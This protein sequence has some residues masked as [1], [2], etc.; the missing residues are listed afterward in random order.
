MITRNVRL[1]FKTLRGSKWRSLMT[2]TGIILGIV[3]VVTV[4]SLGEGIKRQ[5]LSQISQQG[6]NLITVRPGNFVKRDNSG[7]IVGV[8]GWN[9]LTYTSGSLSETDLDVVGRTPGVSYAVPMTLVNSGVKLDEEQYVGGSVIASTEQLPAALNQKVIYGKFF[10]TNELDRHVAVIGKRVAEQLFKE[11]VPI[12]R[13]LTIRGQDFVV[14][15]IF[16]E[17]ADSPLP[18]NPD[19][20]KAVFIPHGLSIG[21][22]SGRQLIQILVRPQSG[23]SNQTL[24]ANLN[25]QLQVA[26]GG[27]VDYT[28][29]AQEENLAL[30]G[31]V[32]DMFTSFIGGI[33]AIMLLIGGLGI[34]NIMLV[35][36]SERTRE[37]GI[38]KA[39]GATNRQIA[40]QFFVEATV[41]SC[42]GGAIGIILAY[43]INLTLRILTHLQPVTTWPVVLTASGVSLAI[44]ILFGLIP[45]VRAARKDPIEALR[46]E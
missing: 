23:I 12:G 38:R 13:S 2:M 6:S 18:L 35:L 22:D 5:V 33:A 26:H 15:G 27:Q 45:A 40:S 29:L 34:M 41:L 1:A 31:S 10:Q 37:I 20:N 19:F 8:S 43:G 44:G 11:N 7:N 16:D 36:V 42:V 4:V 46:Y 21:L 3:S 9:S 25:S 17:F 14:I 39:I 32:F 30:V 28:L 24:I